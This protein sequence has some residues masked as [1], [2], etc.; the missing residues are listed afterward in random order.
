[1][2]RI[3]IGSTLLFL[4]ACQTSPPPQRVTAPDS[5][6]AYLVPT[7]QWLHPAGDP[8]E[9][10]G[11]PVDLVLSPDGQML[12]AKDNRGL[13]VIDAV[14]WKVLQEVP[15]P[16]RHGGGSPHGI[17]L[18]KAGTRLWASASN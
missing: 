4:V 1:M 11:R 8:V 18:N 14:S 5:S 2:N 13:V 9:F 15:F 10:A 17:L 12:F 3:W 6:G 16:D 7:A